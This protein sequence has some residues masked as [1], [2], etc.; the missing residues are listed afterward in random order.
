MVNS[1]SPI[2]SF[3]YVVIKFNFIGASRLYNV[4]TYVPR[5]SRNEFLTCE[6]TDRDNASSCCI[7]ED[8]DVRSLRNSSAGKMVLRM[9]KRER[10]SMTRREPVE[11]LRRGG[12]DF[13]L[14]D[15]AILASDATLDR[16][17]DYALGIYRY[18][19]LAR[20]YVNSRIHRARFLLIVSA[21][22]NRDAAAKSPRMEIA[23]TREIPC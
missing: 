20:R 18:C 15:S 11:G 2:L 21:S 12:E 5:A 16:L 23:Q 3:S 8:P 1:I 19:Y 6:F 7:L 22:D 14:R 13:F 9:G 10:D 4:L 17:H